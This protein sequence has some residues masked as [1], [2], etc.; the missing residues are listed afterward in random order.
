M[1]K[2]FNDLPEGTPM[3]K[4]AFTMIELIF[5]IIVIGILAV[6]AMPRMDRDLRQ[7]AK[8]NI[9]S[10]IRYT[11]HLALVDDK[12][13]PEDNNW[14]ANLWNINFQ[15][16]GSYYTISSNSIAAL[17]PVN[18]KKM[19]GTSTGSPNV[20]IG[21]KY[22]ITTIA[23]TVG[24]GI[25]TGTTTALDIAF[26][27]LGRPFRGV[28]TAINNYDS[29]VTQDCTLTFSAPNAFPGDPIVISISRETGYVSGD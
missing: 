14:Q 2:K 22:G 10:A 18:G 24:C 8:D 28:S 16:D 9:L 11:Q 7:G 3:K 27:N 5:V 25:A 4:P 13:D 21:K 6:L 19:D 29:Y 26:D 23:I 12:T 15:S 20:L 17:D 1:M